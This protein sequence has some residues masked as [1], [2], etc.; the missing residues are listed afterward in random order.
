M[1]KMFG[2]QMKV[3]HWTSFYELKDAGLQPYRTE[4]DYWEYLLLN[5]EELYGF[6]VNKQQPSAFLDK[7][8]DE[9]CH[10]GWHTSCCIASFR[11]KMRDN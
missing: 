3:I 4:K 2:V 11:R 1:S 8:Y 5:D 9:E 7:C 10:D 6:S